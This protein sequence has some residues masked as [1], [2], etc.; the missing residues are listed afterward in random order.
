MSLT[1]GSTSTY[2]CPVCLAKNTELTDLTKTWPLRMA[3]HTQQL[4]QQAR[5][6]TRVQDREALLSKYGLRDVEVGVFL[7]HVLPLS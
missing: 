1:R 6:L 4:I 7:S 5:E 3:A 2:P